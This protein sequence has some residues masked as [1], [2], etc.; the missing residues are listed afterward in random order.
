MEKQSSSARIS[1]FTPADDERETAVNYKLPSPLKLAIIG[2]GYKGGQPREGVDQ[3][4]AVIREAGIKNEISLLGWEVSD[5]GD[6]SLSEWD[7]EKDPAF[8]IIKHPRQVGEACQKVF[9]R[10]RSVSSTHFVL[11]LGGDHSLAIGSIAAMKETWSDLCIVWVDAHGDINNDKTTTSGNIHGMPLGF[12]AGLNE[13]PVPG[14]EWLKQ[15]IDIKH[16]VYI[17]LRHVDFQEKRTLH[18]LG[19]KAFSMHEVDKFGIGRVMEMALDHIDPKRRRP[20]HLSL[21][22][23]GIDPS[24]CPSTGTRVTGGLTYREANYICEVLSESGRLVSMDITEFN[25]SIGTPDEVRQTAEVVVALAR[26]ALGH[27]LLYKDDLQIK[28][29]IL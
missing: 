21:D 6:L 10:A 7:Q 16:L 19:I 1:Y 29:K 3:G 12:L 2:A 13:K 14:F 9:E 8:G 25:P 26:G 17:G 28:S 4:P 18:K 22:I 5:L 11:T 23:D 15:T 27:E 24:V 20:I